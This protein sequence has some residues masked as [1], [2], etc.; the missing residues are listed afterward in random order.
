M[1]SENGQNHP[2]DLPQ[3]GTR[4]STSDARMGH[5]T[6]TCPKRNGSQRSSAVVWGLPLAQAIQCGELGHNI[7]DRGPMSVWYWSHWT[8]SSQTWILVKPHC[9]E[10]TFWRWDHHSSMPCRYGNHYYGFR[11]TPLLYSDIQQDSKPIEAT[12][13]PA[14]QATQQWAFSHDIW[15]DILY[16]LTL[17]GEWVDRMME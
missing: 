1:C 12:T 8:A 6:R 15:W 17:P 7:W 14:A 10:Y 16:S 2:L 5:I 11:E 3:N 4:K 9:H 13:F